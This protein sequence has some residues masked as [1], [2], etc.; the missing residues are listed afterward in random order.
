MLSDPIGEGFLGEAPLGECRD[1][2]NNFGIGR[3]KIM[4][5][6]AQER[7]H[8]QE[9][10]ALV[11]VS[12]RMVLHEPKRVRGREHRQICAFLVVPLLLGSCQGG[13]EDILVANPR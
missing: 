10:D 1:L 8:R 5:V 9:P 7:C 6:H 11:A 3:Y 4:A 2:S 13:F 12:V